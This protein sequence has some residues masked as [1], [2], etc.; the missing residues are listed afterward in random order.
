MGLETR[1]KVAVVQMDVRIG[2]VRTNL[3]RV[4]DYLALAA[5]A[6]ADLVV[7]PECALQGYCFDSLDEVRQLALRGSCEKDK[8]PLLFDPFGELVNA[9]CRHKTMA[10]VGFIEKTDDGRLFNSCM[11]AG[12]D[13]P[14]PLIYRKTHLPTL[15]VDR[16][17]S[18]GDCL[19]VWEVQGVRFAP[20]ICYDVRFPEA[21]RVVSLR[22]AD[23]LVVPTNWPVGAESAPQYVL[24]AR[25]REN[26]VFV[27]AANRTGVERGRKFI[28]RS[29]IIDHRGEYL[30]A[31][32]NRKETILYAEIEPVLARNKRIVIEPGAWEQDTVGDRRPEL[33]GA[34]VQ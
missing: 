31:A 30:A 21:A 20:L 8:D 9:C 34:L 32:K 2:C 3:R 4:L 1:L 7:F 28:G 11:L 10:V 33:Y 19:P 29:V 13:L 16:F 14:S 24:R 12:P 27:V 5:G 25:A 17:L 26:G 18:K 22:G 23:V 6:G 15:G